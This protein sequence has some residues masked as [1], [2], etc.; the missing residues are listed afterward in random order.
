MHDFLLDVRYGVRMLLKTPVVAA[1]A[2]AS[3]AI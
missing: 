3:L 2:A 1:V